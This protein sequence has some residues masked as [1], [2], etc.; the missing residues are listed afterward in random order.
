M[1]CFFSLLPGW[2]LFTIA[3]IFG[4]TCYLKISK[5]GGPQFACFVGL[6]DITCLKDMEA[7]KED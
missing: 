1:T 2:F 7:R 5:K 3:I 6:G 4:L